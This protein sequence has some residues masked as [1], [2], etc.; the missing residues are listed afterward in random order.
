M[1]LDALRN[2]FVQAHLV[3]CPQ[4]AQKMLDLGLFANLEQL[5]GKAIA[6]L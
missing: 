4:H 1:A 5:I 2:L 3:D 6:Q